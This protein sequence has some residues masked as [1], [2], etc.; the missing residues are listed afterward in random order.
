MRTAAAGTAARAVSTAAGGKAAASS[1]TGAPSR[2]VRQTR[3]DAV[4]ELARVSERLCALCEETL[5]R[6]GGGARGGASQCASSQ[7]ASRASQSTSQCSRAS[8]GRCSAASSAAGTSTMTAGGASRPLRPASTFG[9]GAAD[10]RTSVAR[11]LQAAQAVQRRLEQQEAVLTFTSEQCA[12]SV[13]ALHSLYRV[14]ARAA[15][16]GSTPLGLS[17]AAPMNPNILSSGP[18]DAALHVY[19]GLEGDSLCLYRTEEHTRVRGAE[20]FARLGALEGQVS[21]AGVPE[22]RRR[23]AVRLL[24]RRPTCRVRLL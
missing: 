13:F 4:R 23:I 9:G 3:L 2:A 16:E 15:T 19:V 11:A 12:Q 17:L 1:A 7:C 8:H 10:P 20:P 14:Y 6:L 21:A 18:A 24:P 5:G 22:C